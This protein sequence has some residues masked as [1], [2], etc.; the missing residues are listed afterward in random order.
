MAVE[1]GRT[2]YKVEAVIA[3]A[4]ADLKA[5]QRS[6]DGNKV[7]RGIAIDVNTGAVLYDAT[8]DAMRLDVS[9]GFGNDKKPLGDAGLRRFKAAMPLSVL[10]IHTHTGIGSMGER[11][12]GAFVLPQIAEARLITDDAVYVARK[13]A[14][15]ARLPEM[16]TTWQA[17]TALYNHLYDKLARDSR[18]TLLDEESVKAA[19]IAASKGVAL[20]LR[21][22][23]ETLER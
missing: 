8:G 16:V 1:Q 2:D 6:A 13:T 21:V 5:Y 20:E 11:D 14:A 15:F 12:W 19:T 22:V 17:V 18:T 10:D 9:T 23:F 3:K 4:M 7:E